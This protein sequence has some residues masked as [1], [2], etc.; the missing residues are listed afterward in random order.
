MNKRT[1]VLKVVVLVLMIFS[2]TLAGFTD[3]IPRQKL[4]DGPNAFDFWVGK[5]D[6][7]WKDKD[8]TIATG[9]NSIKKILKDKI[10]RE[11]FEVLTGSN[12]GFRGK[13]WSVY[14]SAT[15]VWRQTWVDTQ[16]AYL[17]FFGDT[18]DGNRIF[19]REFK[20]AKG[21]MV[22]QRMIFRNISDDEFDWDWQISADGKSWQ[23]QWSIHYKKNKD[24]KKKKKNKKNKKNMKPVTK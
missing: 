9:K 16:G 18:T 24:K 23:T 17:D 3:P 20:N 15:K 8:G 14:N 4:K 6:L 5:W 7:T 13:S 2:F 19:K 22:I 1:S 21:Q 11:N 10:V 12:K